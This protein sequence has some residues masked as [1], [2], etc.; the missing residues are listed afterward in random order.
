MHCFLNNYL[1]N[2]I[3]T[4]L[5]FQEMDLNIESTTVDYFDNRP[6]KRPKVLKHVFQTIHCHLLPSPPH[7]SFRNVLTLL[8][9]N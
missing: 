9:Q 1:N 8:V 4:F 3:I 7:L 2:L 5:L 6:L